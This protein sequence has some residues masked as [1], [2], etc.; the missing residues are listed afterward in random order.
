MIA[1]AV[2]LA[3]IV[4]LALLR[5]GI[6]VEYGADGVFVTARAGPIPIRIF[7]RKAKLEKAKKKKIKKAKKKKIV[8]EQ[9]KPGGLKGFLDI[10][11]TVKN[12]LGRLRRRLLIRDLTIRFTAANNDPSKTAMTY[13]AANAAF[14]VI[15][16]ALEKVFRI[17][18][19]D[20]RAYANFY[21]AAPSIYVKASVSLAVWEAVYIALA[22]LPLIRKRVSP[23]RGQ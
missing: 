23:A 5:F 16:P 10:L 20:L 12:T 9:K 7:P 14:G 18:R 11:S 3:V 4:F 21:D 2:V 6:S 1:S 19:R 17:K 13:G 15:L 8:H 22:L